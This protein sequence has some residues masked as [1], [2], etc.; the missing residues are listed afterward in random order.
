M[1]SLDVDKVLVQS[2]AAMGLRV[3]KFT[4]EQ[5][6]AGMGCFGREQLGSKW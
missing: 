3:M 2:C 4:I 5:D 6:M 1:E